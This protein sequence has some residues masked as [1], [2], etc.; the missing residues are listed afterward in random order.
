MLRLQG[1]KRGNYSLLDSPAFNAL[2]VNIDG[3]ELVVESQEPAIISRKPATVAKVSGSL[4]TNMPS[5]TETAG[6]T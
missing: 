2:S 6:L 3:R 4:S 5:R 1:K